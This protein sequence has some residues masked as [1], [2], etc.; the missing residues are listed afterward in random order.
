MKRA[1]IFSL[2]WIPLLGLEAPAASPSKGSDGPARVLMIVGGASHDYENLPP[3]LARNLV[4]RKGLAITVTADLGELH[5]DNIA[6]FDV[7][8]FHDCRQD[9]LDEA[10]RTAIVEHVR[11]GKG[12]VSMHC[13]LWSYKWW[14]EWAKLLGGEVTTHDHFGSF[15]VTVLDPLHATMRDVGRGFT[16]TDEPY[17][18]NKRDPA[19]NVLVR[20]SRVHATPDGKRRDGPEPQVWTRRVGKGRVFVTTFGHDARAQNNPK[21]LALMHHGLLWAA[22]RLPDTRHNVLTDAE[23]KAG[24]KLL[25]NG[26]D[27]TG[28]TGPAGLWKVERG[29]LVGRA[30]DLKH[31]VFLVHQGTFADFELRLSARLVRGNSGIQFRSKSYPDHVVKGYQADIGDK[32]FGTLYS[33]GTGRDKLVEGWK[34]KGEKVAAVDGWNDFVIKAAGPEITITLNG[35]TTAR[36]TETNANELD[37]GV[38][39]LQLH[40]GPPMAVR[41]RDIRIRV[42]SP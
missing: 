11:S 14:P 23:K 9:E 17:L 24:F 5:P 38:I 28:W 21:F 27:L 19:A 41:F 26:K 31:N 13:S 32:L 40:T 6:R 37:R 8:M 33:E 20:T 25:F 10:T 1:L 22:G 7:L 34:G 30:R 36:F 4:K 35:V 2:P 12:L 18:V 16:I 29:E 15:P 42:L 3:A 39:G